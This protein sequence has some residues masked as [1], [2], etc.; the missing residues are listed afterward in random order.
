[1]QNPDIKI[2]KKH[3]L[4]A[5]T[6]HSAIK[7]VAKKYSSK[8]FPVKLERVGTSPVYKAKI[9]EGAAKGSEAEMGFNHELIQ[10]EIKLPFIARLMKGTVE[11]EA[12]KYLDAIITDLQ[13]RQDQ[14]K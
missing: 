14:A 12:S 8:D 4:T 9:D 2:V 3:T 1:M 5:D 11:K 13:K 6:I 10:L 7:E